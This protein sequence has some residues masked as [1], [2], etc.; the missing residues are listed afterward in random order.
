MLQPQEEKVGFLQSRNRAKGKKTNKQTPL[1][2][3]TR[4]WDRLRPNPVLP[5]E[6][7]STP[8]GFIWRARTR[9]TGCRDGVQLQPSPC[10]RPLSLRKPFP[11]GKPPCGSEKA[12]PRSRLC[13]FPAR[14]TCTA[15]ALPVVSRSGRPRR[16]DPRLGDAVKWAADK[17][18]PG[19][20]V[21]RK[22]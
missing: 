8:K 15:R 16:H 13:S 3:S 2:R 21:S 7:P 4:A 1:K 9:D 5:A 20:L 10:R 6:Q 22:M 11:D 19:E 18:H 12:A 14:N 17:S